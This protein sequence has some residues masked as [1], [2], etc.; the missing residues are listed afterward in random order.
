MVGC[1]AAP[2]EIGR[3]GRAGRHGVQTRDDHERQCGFRDATMDDR[4][5]TLPRMQFPYPLDPLEARL[6]I[7]ISQ[8]CPHGWTE[9]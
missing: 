3:R 6:V 4:G 7:G 1:A 2:H 9:I 5:Q 8:P